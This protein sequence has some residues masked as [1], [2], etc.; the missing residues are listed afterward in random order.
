MTKKEFEVKYTSRGFSQDAEQAMR[1][2]VI[3]G[4][5]ELITNC[6]DAYGEKSGEIRVVVNRTADSDGSVE[7]AVT[8]KAKGLS[9]EE[10]EKAFSHLGSET[11]GF[12]DG[13][14]VR[15]L[16]GRGSKDTA[17]FGRTVFESIKAGVFSEIILNRD[18]KG[19]LDYRDATTDDYGR[20]G[21]KKSENGLTA[22][23]QI[24][25]LRAKVPELSKLAERL[26]SHVQLRQLNVKNNVIISEFKKDKQ[27]KQAP[28]V[29]ELPTHEEIF[30]E[31]IVENLRSNYTEIIQGMWQGG[32]D[33]FEY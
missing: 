29:W 14:S 25:P 23:I 24:Q 16:F 11:S 3:R 32:D 33:E 18:G 28:I 27:T 13:A 8:D 6:D 4:L 30:D 5:I 19:S 9:P 26:S 1:G 2:D 12:A 15:G 20:L 10:M 31:D 17:W 21:L 22:R 7:V